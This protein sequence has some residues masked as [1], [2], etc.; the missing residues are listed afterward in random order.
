MEALRATSGLDEYHITNGCDHGS[1]DD[2]GDNEQDGDDDKDGDDD[3]DD[4]SDVDKDGDDC[5][6]GDDENN[7]DE[8]KEPRIDIT[9]SQNHSSGQTLRPKAS[10]S[11]CSA[12]DTTSE[13][14]NSQGLGQRAAGKSAFLRRTIGNVVK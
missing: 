7:D 11:H 4:H 3:G 1:G 14:S 2:N 12:P 13:K 5:N 9:S 10:R 6:G 8:R